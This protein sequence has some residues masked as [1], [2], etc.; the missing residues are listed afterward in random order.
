M[1]IRIERERLFSLETEHTL[2]QMK[3]DD[4]IALQQKELQTD[5]CCICGTAERQKRI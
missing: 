4:H 3:A 5:C 2:Y 1:S